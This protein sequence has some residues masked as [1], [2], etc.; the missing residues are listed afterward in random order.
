MVIKEDYWGQLFMNKKATIGLLAIV[1][2]GTILAGCGTTVTTKQ[3]NKLE[4]QQYLKNVQASKSTHALLSQ[5]NMTNYGEKKISLNNPYVPTKYDIVVNN[6]IVSAN[7]IQPL[8]SSAMKHADAFPNHNIKT[9][10]N[11]TAKMLLTMLESDQTGIKWGGTTQPIPSLNGG[12]IESISY[13]NTYMGKKYS[14]DNTNGFTIYYNLMLNNGK[15]YQNSIVMSPIP[16]GGFT[17][18]T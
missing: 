8:P 16:G 2:V 5:K 11:N 14:S 9:A 13:I 15:Q 6:I 1:S 3:I 12:R 10:W 18:G 17:I 7:P 4:N